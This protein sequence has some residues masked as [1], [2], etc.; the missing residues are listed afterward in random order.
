MVK[1]PAPIIM[2]T[3]KAVAYKRPKCRCKPPVFTSATG[4]L[5]GC[6]QQ[7]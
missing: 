5:L 6:A 4:N 3:F 7:I 1:T 2:V